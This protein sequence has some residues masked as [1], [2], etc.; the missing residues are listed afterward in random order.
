MAVER[1]IKVIAP[2][3]ETV[4]LELSMQD[5]GQAAEVRCPTEWHTPETLDDIATACI[6]MADLIRSGGD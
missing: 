3:G 1:N 4:A 5:G 6:K 2:D